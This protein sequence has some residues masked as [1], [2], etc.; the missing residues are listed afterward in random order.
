M[1]ILVATSIVISSLLVSSCSTM[2]TPPN[3]FGCVD[4]DLD[5]AWTDSKASGRVLVVPEWFRPTTA[6]LITLA[7][8]CANL[9]SSN[10]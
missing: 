8:T 2:E 7:T 1:K 9:E 10:G 5:P 4:V 3:M 6:E